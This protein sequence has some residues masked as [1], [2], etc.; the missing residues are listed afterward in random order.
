[1]QYG[2]STITSFRNPYVKQHAFIL[3]S[4]NQRG[5]EFE[6]SIQGSCLGSQNWTVSFPKDRVIQTTLENLKEVI[7]DDF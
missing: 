5:G 2:D 1:M 3:L 4:E 7:N 6:R